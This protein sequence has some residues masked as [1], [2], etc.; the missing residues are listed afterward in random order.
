MVPPGNGPGAV[1]QHQPGQQGAEHRVA[2]AH[3]DAPQAVVPAGA[4]G[5]ADEHHRGEVGGA[6]GEG[7]DPG[8]GVAAPHG[9]AG[10]ALPLAGVEDAHRQHEDGVHADDSPDGELFVHGLS[11][12]FRF[13]FA[14]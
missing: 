6:V 10:H 2:H 4:P 14:I 9:K 3:Q 11:L 1:G 12:P 8:A 13:A 7:G 5:V